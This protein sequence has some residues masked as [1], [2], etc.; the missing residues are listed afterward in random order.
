M[1]QKQQRWII[2]IEAYKSSRILITE[3]LT[4]TPLL[5]LYDQFSFITNHFF[6]RFSFITNTSLNKDDESK[7]LAGC[8][9]QDRE[10]A[11]VCDFERNLLEC[12][13]SQMF[14]LNNMTLD[15]GYMSCKTSKR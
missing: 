7:Y 4:K 11:N 10:N 13:G 9:K 14:D 12:R 1:K 8:I 15:Q 6:S 3:I 2:A 5:V